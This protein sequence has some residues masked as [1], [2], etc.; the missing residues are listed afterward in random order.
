MILHRDLKLGNFFINEDLHLF[1][2]DFGMASFYDSSNPKSSLNSSEIIGTPNYT[3]IEI[4]NDSLYSPASEI[5]SIG[6]TLFYMKMGYAPFEGKN[7]EKTFFNIK[8][9]EEDYIKEKLIKKKLNNLDH[10]NENLD[11]LFNQFIIKCLKKNINERICLNKI[12][13]KINEFE[14][15]IQ[16]GEYLVHDTSNE[17]Y[18][19]I[20]EI[21]NNWN[22][23]LE[24]QNKKNISKC[25][26]TH[27][28]NIL[29]FFKNNIL[30]HLHQY[31]I[32]D[33]NNVLIEIHKKKDL[34][35]INLK[36]NKIFAEIDLENCNFQ[37]IILSFKKN[38]FSKFIFKNFKL[39]SEPDS[40]NL[41]KLNS[42]LE[43]L[44][45]ILTLMEDRIVN[46]QLKLSTCNLI[47]GYISLNKHYLYLIMENDINIFEKIKSG[48]NKQSISDQRLYKI[49]MSRS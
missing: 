47:T 37:Y 26:Q 41:D 29:Y 32:I 44:F 24:L 45:K 13:T 34:I 25:E 49:D 8:N 40:N 19:I 48:L 11:E 15:W 42:L 20:V 38:N 10:L 28:E 4:L 43:Y 36:K 21:K 14:F 46:Y 6:I 18:E 35:K 31:I 3:S 12:H 27:F 30:D 23:I 16:T 2:G 9:F 39:K 33:T 1:L 7:K 17:Y 5:W 22:R